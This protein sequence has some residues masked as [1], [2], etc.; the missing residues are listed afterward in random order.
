V[1][2]YLGSCD[3][4][5]EDSSPLQS[6]TTTTYNGV[7]GWYQFANLPAG[8]YCVVLSKDNY[9]PGGAL[10]GLVASPAHAS[11]DPATDSNASTNLRAD[12]TLAGD[13]DTIDFGLHPVP[14]IES[15][16]CYVVA[17]N[18]D[19]LGLIDRTSGQVQ[20][21]GKVVPSDG[22]NLAIRPEGFTIYNVAGEDSAT[23]L[24]TIDDQTAATTIINTDIGLQDVDALAFD[25]GTGILYAVAVNPNPGV[26]YMVDPNTGATT[27]VVDLQRPSPD[28]LASA[29]D[30]HIDGLAIDPETG[31][32]YGAYS[33][34]S[35]KS[36]LVTI[37][38]STGEMTLVGGPPDDP[39][40]MG[41]NDVEDISFHP[42]GT[43][44]GVLGDQGAIGNDPD[45]S[46]E[47]LVIIDKNTAAA[48]PV[49]PYGTP[50]QGLENWDVEAF[51]C[52]V[53]ATGS[54]GDFVWN[55]ANGNGVQDEGSGFGIPN[56]T[57]RLYQDDGDNVFEPGTDDTLVDTQTTDSNGL[58]DFTH[59]PAGTYWVDVDEST[60]PSGYTLT[61]ANEP[62]R[63]D[64]ASGE[65]YNDADFGYVGRG[66]ITGTVFYDWNENGTQD[67]GE[68]GIGG[69]EV[70]LYKDDGDDTYDS[71]DTLEECVTTNSDGTYRFEDYYPGVYFVVETQPSGLES[72]TPNVRRV[73]LVVAGASGLASGNDFG[74][75]VKGR[76][77]D[78]T[79]ID[80]DG[81]GVQDPGET[82]GLPNVPLHITGV[83]VTNAHIDITVT[84]SITGYY[85]VEDLLP[86]T[87]TVTA[88]SNAQGFVRTSTSPLTTTLSEGHMEDLTLDFGYIAPTGVQ[89]IDFQ[90][91]KGDRQ[92]ELTWTVNVNH[93]AV[94]RFRVWR[95]TDQGKWK[96][97]TGA[98]LEAREVSGS[99]AFYSYTDM[100]VQ[101]G[102]VYE[103][104]L[105]SEDGTFLGP[106][107][108]S[109]RAQRL[110]VPV[111]WGR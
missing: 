83:D 33:A 95:S 3:S 97:L 81:D 25:P 20:V 68:S 80:S 85:L 18:G 14:P 11:G 36:Y 51:A 10:V 42:S 47:G 12:V 49:G 32:M 46:F 56:V 30:P 91:E 109:L 34:W 19:L 53:P 22:E 13:D 26:L 70:C 106:W 104:R 43:F 16:V 4:L 52:S 101:P 75:V 72:T 2:L 23:P 29:Y 111:V 88:P 63:V 58:Y 27:H 77:G 1:D 7:D 17:D 50:L 37:N 44:Y 78:R 54:I 39:G 15:G 79:W 86:G 82:S 98:W 40:Y 35:T 28:P 66:D 59:L 55:D 45:G 89:L 87:Y 9:N 61:T 103:Y 69:V 64:L 31:I 90:V 100:T 76:I 84:T 73:E 8:N 102:H 105:E 24:I 110:F 21:I 41:V 99:R 94:P 107:R 92:V 74:E 71:G 38:P 96:L 93:S 57:L 65:D 67:P 48:T 62:H 6:T 60:L 5:T 108:V